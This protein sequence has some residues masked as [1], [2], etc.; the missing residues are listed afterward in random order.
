MK[1]NTIVANICNSAFCN[2]FK[3]VVLKFIRPEPNQVFIRTRLR[4]NHLAD[5]KFRHNFQDCV[6]PICSYDQEIET[7]THFLFYCSNYHC[8][9]QTLVEKVNKID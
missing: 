8:A 2:A 1:R 9:R 3:K 6:Y 4:L 7:S 5:H